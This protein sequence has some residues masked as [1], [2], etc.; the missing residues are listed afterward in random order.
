VSSSSARV[1]YTAP[2]GRVHRGFVQTTADMKTG[3]KVDAW[4]DTQGRLVAPPRTHTQM[5]VDA[6]ALGLLTACGVCLVAV[7]VWQAGRSRL[8]QRR[9]RSWDRAWLT[10]D[11]RR[12]GQL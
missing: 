3:E 8:D 7:L 10:F 1:R 2:D 4:S 6:T 11:A 12:S 5:L 9:F